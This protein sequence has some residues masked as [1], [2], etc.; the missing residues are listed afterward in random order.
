MKVPL[1]LVIFLIPLV[2][3]NVVHK[4]SFTNW[5]KI[6]EEVN[7]AQ[8]TWKARRNFSPQISEEAIQKLL[9][10]T[11]DD[12]SNAPFKKFETKANIPKSF[13]ARKVWKSCRSIGHI[14]DQGY[15][16][17]CW[18]VAAA[19][20][21]TDRYCIASGGKFKQHLSMEDLLS[22]CMECG[23]GCDGGSPLYAWYHIW[24]H[25]ITSGGDYDS[26]DGCK[27]YSFA[28]CEHHM[29]GSRP[30]CDSFGD[31]PTPGCSF[32]CHNPSYARGYWSDHH[33]VTDFYVLNSTEKIQQEIME[34]G[35]VEASFV[36]YED[37]LAYKS[38]VY[39]HLIGEKKGGHAVKIIGWGEEGGTPYWLVVNSWNS[40]WGEKG[41]FRILRGRNECNI[42]SFIV[43]G[44]PDISYL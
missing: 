18:A 2:Y 33:R 44:T 31:L 14:R 9:G 11:L 13:D 8:S 25:G 29:E 19:E 22:C 26:N 1:I 6:I 41:T 42:E 35:P 28:P 23:K 32:K 43:A 12:F 27:P 40:D 39:Q 36:V 20:A 30:Q 21:V 4:K 17:S 34:H 38:G 7:S 16:G 3:G 15:C 5:E 37:F 24:R 10:A